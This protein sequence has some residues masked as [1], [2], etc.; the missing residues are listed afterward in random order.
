MRV[1]VSRSVTLSKRPALWMVAVQGVD[2]ASQTV[3]GI[4]IARLLGRAAL[5]DFTYGFSFAAIVS[6]VLLFGSG[7]VAIS[8]Y[9]EGRHDPAKVMTTSL[10]LWTRGAA[11]CA[12][13]TLLWQW[14]TTLD[15]SARWVLSLAVTALILNGLASVLNQ[16]IVAW[17]ASHLDLL[18]ML[19]SR[20]ILLLLIGDAGL[21]GDL[22]GAVA[23]YVVA[24]VVLCVGRALIVHF[25]LFRL[26][27]ARDRSLEE[28][29]WSRGRHVGIGSVF[30]SLS[31]RA[32]MLMLHAWSGAEQTGVYGASYR[33]INGLDAAS[34]AIAAGTYPNIVRMVTTGDRRGARRFSVRVATLLSVSIAVL[35]PVSGLLIRTVY[36]SKFAEAGALF[37][38]LLAAAALQV[39]LVFVHKWCI[40][41]A[42]ESMLPRGQFIAA[43]VNLLSN[44]ALIPRFGAMGAAWA[45]LF[46]ELSLAAFYFFALNLRSQEP[47]HGRVV[48]ET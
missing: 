31:A 22:R 23:S 8:L 34:S 32:D 13:L 10:R 24:A 43:T 12:T 48:H 41:T 11:L 36:G 18:V 3:A 33:I 1:A 30:G 6:V 46:A 4:A 29:V 2:I 19:T 15:L 14:G 38:V 47:T 16:A 17:G 26:R 25:R 5:G 44:A 28:V 20:A 27:L 35:I 21:R 9:A 37:A 7:D 45:T 42:R 39:S 40:A